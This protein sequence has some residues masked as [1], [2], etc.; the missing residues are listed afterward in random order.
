MN[1]G[2]CSR[3]PGLRLPLGFAHAVHEA[4]EHKPRDTGWNWGAL[5]GGSYLSSALL[6]ASSSPALTEGLLS[7]PQDWEVSPLQPA[8]LSGELW[9]PL[10]QE[11]FALCRCLCSAHT[12]AW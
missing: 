10:G 4:E 8:V 6:G 3:G 12:Q 7:Y 11:D 9:D 5:W 1:S 2:E